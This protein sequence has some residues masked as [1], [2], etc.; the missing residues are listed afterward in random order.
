MRKLT[1]AEV[2]FTIRCE[3]EGIPVRGNA[4]GSGNDEDDR[5][6]EEAIIDELESGNPWAW[7][8]IGVIAEWNG[9]KA[10]DYLGCCSYENEEDFKESGY[11]V[12][13]KVEA[14]KKLNDDLETMVDRLKPLIG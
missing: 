4:M 8:C 11:Y 6:V 7:C 2:T 10:H 5:R 1:E 3:E 14:L 13:M 12:D 9:F